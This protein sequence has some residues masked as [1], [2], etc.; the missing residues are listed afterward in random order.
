[1]CVVFTGWNT[2]PSHFNDQQLGAFQNFW[3]QKLWSIFCKFEKIVIGSFAICCFW[4]GLI[5]VPMP[6]LLIEKLL[7]GEGRALKLSKCGSGSH[8]E[9]HSDGVS[10]FASSPHPHLFFF[11]TPSLNT[12][13]MRK[14]ETRYYCRLQALTTGQILNAYL[15]CTFK[16]DTSNFFTPTWQGQ[17]PRKTK[18]QG[19]EKTFR[20]EEIP[21]RN[22]LISVPPRTI[23]LR[24]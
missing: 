4:N 13:L 12:S 6:G 1:M 14:K 8:L 3:S 18:G 7:L 22:L 24:C 19:G 21:S 10:C 20:R 5:L 16:T 11:R 15:N 2:P 23:Q 9:L 17:K